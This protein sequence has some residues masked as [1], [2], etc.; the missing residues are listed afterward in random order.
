MHQEIPFCVFEEVMTECGLKAGTSSRTRCI[1]GGPHA[2]KGMHAKAHR[3]HWSRSGGLGAAASCCCQVI[4]A[5][6]VVFY[7]G[8]CTGFRRAGEVLRR[9]DGDAVQYNRQ[10]DRSAGL[11]RC[12]ILL[13]CK[14]PC[15]YFAMFL[16]AAFR[17][18]RGEIIE[19][20]ASGGDALVL[21][22]PGGGEIPTPGSCRHG[23][24]VKWCL[25]RLR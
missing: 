22:P 25:R 4:L 14:M 18:R 3:A 23:C 6:A 8:G 1:A 10:P 15:R 13:P 16:A 20:V 2:G 5:P 9:G 19:Q 21:M 7:L 12:L 24:G 17:S 11:A